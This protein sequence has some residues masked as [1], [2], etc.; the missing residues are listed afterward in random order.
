MVWFHSFL[1]G[2]PVSWTDFTVFVCELEG[3][4]QPQGFVNISANG[5]VINSDLTEDAL[6]IND[7]KATEGHSFIFL[8][9]LIS[10]KNKIVDQYNFIQILKYLIF[11]WD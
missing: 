6:A 2:P 1:A 7:E 9:N 10:L 8:V 4:D 3:L 11:M 5:E